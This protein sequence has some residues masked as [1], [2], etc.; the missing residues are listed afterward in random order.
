M[1]S[2]ATPLGHSSDTMKSL[3]LD[4]VRVLDLS[5]VLAGPFCT[6]T[7]GDLGAHVIKVERPVSGDDTRGWGPPF[8]AAGESAYFLSTNRNK[9]SVAADFSNSGDV[10]LLQ[11]LIGAADVVIDNFLP[12]VLSRYGLDKSALLLR[13]GRLIWCTIS[14]FG[15]ES[16][17]P[18]YDFVVQAE[19]GW[20]AITGPADGAPTK[21]GVALVDVM[22]GKD[23]AT[24]ILAALVGRG[25]D[26]P[27]ERSLTITLAASAAAALV[28]VA[29]N[30]LVTGLDARRWGNA[31]PNLVPYQL[32]DAADRSIVVAV[33]TDAQWHAA[34]HALDLP[35][36]AA[37]ERLITNAGRLRHRA[38][39]V[40]G[41][42]ARLR[43]WP[44][45]RWIERLANAGVPCGLVRTVAE[46]LRDVDASPRTGVAPAAG[47]SVRYPPPR[48]DEH[49]ELIRKHY[50]SAFEH[51]PILA[52][53]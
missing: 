13:H 20:M 1:E 33:G 43:E 8:D 23:A 31:H 24:A 48:L 50:W 44:A 37:D 47:G 41:L 29:Q 9:L 12:S 32:F 35:D 10:V 6:M 53:T 49:G 25:A 2:D 27:V 42:A 16:G 34:A 5:R 30:T 38:E 46:A 4:G 3:P 17:R 21:S 11:T 18:G 14:G 15:P 40:A 22:A 26:R 36:L 28:N 19:S 52:S 51:L 39:I 7:L 45:A